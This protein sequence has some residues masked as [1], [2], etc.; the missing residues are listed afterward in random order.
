MGGREEREAHTKAAS[1]A[2]SA[3]TKARLPAGA[4]RGG[5]A[6]L[7]WGEAGGGSSEA[8]AAP[9]AGGAAPAHPAP[10]TAVRLGR[11][12]HRPGRPRSPDSA[13][14]GRPPA[15]RGWG[16]V[17]PR[18]WVR[19]HGRPRGR[20]RAVLTC[21]PSAQQ[22][23][24]S[25]A[26]ARHPRGGPCSA[27]G[28]LLA[29]RCQGGGRSALL[30]IHE[31]ALSARDW[32]DDV[33]APAPLPRHPMRCGRPTPLGARTPASALALGTERRGLVPLGAGR[34]SPPL[35]RDPP[36]G[37]PSWKP[38]LLR[39]LSL[40]GCGEETRLRLFALRARI[41]PALG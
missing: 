32:T 10:R 27:G 3:S 19:S 8:C 4:E 34:R 29:L 14:P 28:P 38:G 13:A 33:P 37:C 7:R 12:A 40:C 17:S 24:E 31:A 11:R 6:G 30:L 20:R 2:S 15:A 16:S 1:P 5:W 9:S 36:P 25:G 21:A 18:P 41:S 23:A 39:Q 35:S 22:R 26:R